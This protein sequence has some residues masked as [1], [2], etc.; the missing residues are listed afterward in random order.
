MQHSPHPDPDTPVVQGVPWEDLAVVLATL[1]TGSI[2]RAA[3]VLQV[4]QSTASRRLAR[5]E[6]RLGQRLFDRTPEG[7]LATP[8]AEALGAHAQLIEG[9]MA[10]VERLMTAGERVPE[11]RIRMA[12]PDGL[13]STW[14]L[15]MLGDFHERHPRIDLDLVI[16]HAV[17][18]LVRREADLALRFVRP[19]QPDL[20]VA[21]LGD[22]PLAPYVHPRLLG[23]APG[24][25]RWMVFDD[26][27]GR[28][29]ETHWVQD[30]VAPA[31]TSRVSLWN[32]L[33][34]G[35]VHG[36]GAG[37]VSPLVAEDAG[38][39]RLPDLP[40]VPSRPLYLVYHQAL[41]DVPRIAAF[42][43]WLV[44]AAATRLRAP[45]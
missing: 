3:G 21:R 24:S 44:A 36:L 22:V 4:S 40:A 23:R 6:E 15:P 1:R 19:T 7:M 32:A 20:V 45:A 33:F 39:V 13:A 18:D 37:V 29:L 8:M 2:N 12:L 41:R 28:Y 34:A 43:A 42:R 17:V 35:L 25:L 11:G 5:V 30:H 27:D 26:P 38:L 10:D 16:G 9:H 14:L 31:R